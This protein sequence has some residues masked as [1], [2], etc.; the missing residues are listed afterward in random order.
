MARILMFLINFFIFNR[1][2]LIYTCILKHN[3]ISLS[4]KMTAFSDSFEPQTCNN[5]QYTQY[6]YVILQTYHALP[7]KKS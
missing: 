2:A 5:M 4:E 1:N 3:L 7:R 6:V